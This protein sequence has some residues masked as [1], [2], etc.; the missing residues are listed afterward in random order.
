MKR[1]GG[2]SFLFYFLPFDMGVICPGVLFLRVVLSDTFDILLNM[3]L[4]CVPLEILVP[5]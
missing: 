2:F 1:L 3:P 5:Y 4:R